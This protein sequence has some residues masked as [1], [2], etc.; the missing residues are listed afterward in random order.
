MLRL[1]S[2]DVTITDA[3]HFAC[4]TED[5]CIDVKI[6]KVPLFSKLCLPL[7]SASPPEIH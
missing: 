6:S 4:F 7:A 2:K 3:R 1:F 5:F